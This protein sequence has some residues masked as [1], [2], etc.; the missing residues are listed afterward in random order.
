[1]KVEAT[2]AF[3][4]EW[5]EYVYGLQDT[6]CSALEAEDG[7]AKFREDNWQRGENGKGGG[8]H[9]RVMEEGAVFEKAGVNV[10]VV[11]GAITEKMVKVLFAELPDSE[12]TVQQAAPGLPVV[13]A[14]YYT[15]LIPLCL[16]P[17][18]TGGILR[19]MMPMEPLSGAGLAAEPI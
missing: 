8:G 18:P 7:K 9:S 14:W 13:S 15:P 1:M 4:Q 10:S 19:R 17:M 3:R 5:I 11:Y 6:I 12:K 16:P 2:K